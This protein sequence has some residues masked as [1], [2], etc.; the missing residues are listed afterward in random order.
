MVS[1]KIS[2]KLVAGVAAIGLLASVACS[3]VDPAR[4]S[5]DP[6]ASA[7]ATTTAP[8]ETAP[9]NSSVVPTPTTPPTV[10]EPTHSLTTP[11]LSEPACE[12]LREIHGFQ[13]FETSEDLRGCVSETVHSTAF[14]G[15]YRFDLAEEEYRERR[16]SP[17]LVRY[18]RFDAQT[19]DW[20]TAV[21]L[22][23]SRTYQR[24]QFIS[25]EE[26]AEVSETLL[27][28]VRGIV[29]RDPDGEVF[30]HW[31][32]PG[33]RYQ[34]RIDPR[35]GDLTIDQFAAALE[36]SPPV[37]LGPYPPGTRTGIDSVDLVIAAVELNDANALGRL[38]A[39]RLE[40]CGIPMIGRPPSCPEGVE[41]GTPVEAFPAGCFEPAFWTVGE[42]TDLVLRQLLDS[43]RYLFAA[44]EQEHEGEALGHEVIFAE[45]PFGGSAWTV[46]V[47]DGQ[48]TAVGTPCWQ[49]A[50][51]R[52][53]QHGRALL[54]LRL[55]PSRSGP[56]ASPSISP[57]ATALHSR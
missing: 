52:A 2:R 3:G 56:P 55:A 10:V 48:V 4:N 45:S 9:T 50:S 22:R 30:A 13:I 29:Q 34:L 24:P 54:P 1:R 5:A 21:S 53:S 40:P 12:P 18:E 31:T 26:G 37:E 49:S 6:S 28:P 41:S 23:L 25:L 35:W 46:H 16:G 7:G 43:A 17:D 47:Q 36:W 42:E 44:L 14:P 51:S 11:E 39:F 33:G 32:E 20:R 57:A 15:V 27:L 8:A 38:L 19:G